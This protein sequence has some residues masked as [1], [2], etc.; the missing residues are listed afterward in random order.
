[1][2]VPPFK[3][4]KSVEHLIETINKLTKIYEVSIKSDETI[5]KE[6]LVEAINATCAI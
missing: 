5:L 3:I 6:R 1:M 4:A 2:Y